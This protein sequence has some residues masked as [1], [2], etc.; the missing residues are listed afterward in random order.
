[1]SAMI[2]FYSRTMQASSPRRVEA[3]LTNQKQKRL[4]KFDLLT[5]VCTPH[6]LI[7]ILIKWLQGSRLLFLSVKYFVRS[8]AGFISR[9]N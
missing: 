1:M 6:Q 9:V 2:G 7:V 4:S 3:Q 8:S 5:G